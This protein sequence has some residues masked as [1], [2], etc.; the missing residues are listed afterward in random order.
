[1]HIAVA[2][3]TK[4]HLNIQFTL[5]SST[6]G[7]PHRISLVLTEESVPDENGILPVEFRHNAEGDLPDW[8]T[9]GWGIASYTLASIDEKYP[10]T[11]I[12]GFKI[13]YY[14]ES[15]S[16]AQCIVKRQAMDRMIIKPL[17]VSSVMHS[18]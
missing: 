14:D 9:R 18:F 10:D 8:D 5:A 15:G 17:T 16:H 13:L 7:K 3:V 11:E 4:E 6:S 12:K 1:M 2:S